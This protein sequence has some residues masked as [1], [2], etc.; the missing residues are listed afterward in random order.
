MLVAPVLA[1]AAPRRNEHALQPTEHA[2]QPKG[3]TRQLVDFGMR[4][5]PSLPM[6]AARPKSLNG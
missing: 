3:T 5:A 6:G 2:L 4:V 1:V